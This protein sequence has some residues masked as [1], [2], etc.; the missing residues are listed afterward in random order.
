[1]LNRFNATFKQM[2]KIRAEYKCKKKNNNIIKGSDNP[3]I[4]LA[5]QREKC[6][7]GCVYCVPD[8]VWLSVLFF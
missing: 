3:L 8:F 4:C 2:S 6:H 1:M 7:S 5:E